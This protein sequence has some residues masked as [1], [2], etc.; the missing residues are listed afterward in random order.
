MTPKRPEELFIA[1]LRS[2]YSNTCHGI[3]KRRT[4]IAPKLPT[5][6]AL[7]YL[8]VSRTRPIGP[9]HVRRLCGSSAARWTRGYATV[10]QTGPPDQPRQIAV[11]GGGITGLTAAHY[12]ARHAPNAHITIYEASNR[13]GGWIDGQHTGTSQGGDVLM[14][15]GPRMLRSGATSNKYDD[16]VLYDVLAN[17]NLQDKIIY[18]E[19]AADSRYVYYPD[20]LVKLPSPELTLDNVF[21]SIRSFLTEPLWSECFHAGMN[22]WA[23]FQRVDEVIQEKRQAIKEPR[24]AFDKDES[25]AEFLER[26]F[27]VSAPV[28]NIVSA[29]LH[30]I[31]GGDVF[32]LSAKHTIFDR[33][34]MQIQYPQPKGYMWFGRK[35]FYLQYD[36]IDGPNGL[37]VIEIA[38]KTRDHNLLAFEDGL[39]TLVDALASD[40]QGRENVTIKINTPVAAVEH[41]PSHV[42][43]SSGERETNKYDQVLST[44]FSGH[45]AQLTQ[46][47]N[48]LPSLAATQAVTILVVNLWYPNPDL[49]KTNPGFG[50]LIPQSVPSEQNPECAL[51]VLFD[52][53][54][55]T[56]DEVKGTKLTVM[57]G[58]HYW[59]DWPVLPSEEMG[60]AMARAVVERHLGISSEE[61]VVT[62]TKL[63]RDCIPQHNVGHRDLMSKAHWELLSA[64]QGR[65]TVAGPSYTTVGIIPAMRAGF[66]AGMRI[67]RGHR[68]PWFQSPDKRYGL[69]PWY[70]QKTRETGFNETPA[71]HVG[72]TGL[73]WATENQFEQM[74]EVQIDTLWFRKW[75]K[76][77]ERFMDDK[78]NW[79]QGLSQNLGGSPKVK[80]EGETKEGENN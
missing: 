69:W 15:R 18:P 28:K 11:L 1:L 76:D 48:S 13:L 10:E 3:F 39:V 75:T 64:F 57:L 61:E 16:L 47:A 2:A 50:Y 40:L 36:I 24:S 80:E 67:A 53:D 65:L 78:G 72:A 5:A 74:S 58:G 38:E 79:K 59:N 60:T 25:V 68:Q 41:K 42:L 22:W 66:D 43:V 51:G 30:G 27:D 52:S 20:H 63:C 45:L 17:L 37:K 71:D 55:E 73:E 14:Q 12:L 70:F 7:S 62:S 31:Y 9:A 29:M 49:I 54:L 26:I 21:G 33:F 46:P 19:G 4:V 44:L 8:A 6:R 77:S 32:K 34:W 56:R 23:H 35:E